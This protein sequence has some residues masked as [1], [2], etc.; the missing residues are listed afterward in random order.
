MT[1]KFGPRD[2]YTIKLLPDKGKTTTKPSITKINKSR[3]EKDHFLD[4]IH[5]KLV[6]GRGTVRKS[7]AGTFGDRA[8]DFRKTV[9]LRRGKV[10]VTVD[11]LRFHR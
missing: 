9:S 1:T 2:K 3:G 4:K 7:I 5:D 10:D 11:K 6:R 8:A